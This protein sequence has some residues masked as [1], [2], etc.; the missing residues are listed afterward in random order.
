MS[1]RARVCVCT[2]MCVCEFVG[3]VLSEFVFKIYARVCHF[4]N[5]IVAFIM[6]TETGPHFE[7]RVAGH[8]DGG[9]YKPNTGEYDCGFC[10]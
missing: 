9:V 4:S 1:A 7:A 5:K 8:G 3:C 10:Q 2:S 6:G